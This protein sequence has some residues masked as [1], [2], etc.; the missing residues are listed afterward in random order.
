MGPDFPGELQAREVD[1]RSLLCIWNIEDY[2]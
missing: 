1:E 2:K